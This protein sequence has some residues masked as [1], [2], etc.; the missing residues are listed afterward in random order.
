MVNTSNVV[1]ATGHPILP[2][3]DSAQPRAYWP[4]AR[5][6]HMDLHLL[7]SWR[8]NLMLMGSEGVIQDTLDKLTPRLAEPVRTWNRSDPLELPSPPQSGTLILREVGA[9]SA[10]DQWRLLKWLEQ[11]VGRVQV[12]STSSSRLL[13]MVDAGAFLE[14]LYYRLNVVSVDVTT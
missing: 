6:A 8:V 1:A 9:L 12:V 10:I 7:S 11:S 3:D 5:V 2:Q 4:M 14:T 13:A